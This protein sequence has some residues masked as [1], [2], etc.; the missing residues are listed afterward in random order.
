METETVAE[1]T[2][3]VSTAP[4]PVQAAPEVQT[5]TST[6]PVLACGPLELEAAMAIASQFATAEAPPPPPAVSCEPCP[7]PNPYPVQRR[8]E[9]QPVAAVET[10]PPPACP[11][12]PSLLSRLAPALG[13]ALFGGLAV[14]LWSRPWP[15]PIRVT[16]VR[17]A[18]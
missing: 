18:H 17:K 8:A 10:A 14:V 11:A 9:S 3:P 5:G 7:A 13:G 6:A 1:A 16:R 2:E 15:R 12:G 4:A